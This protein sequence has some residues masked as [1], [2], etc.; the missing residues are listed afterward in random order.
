MILYGEK[1]LNLVSMR[2][3]KDDG[4]N[5]VTNVRMKKVLFFF[6]CL[7]V[8]FN[9]LCLAKDPDNLL[10]LI[11]LSRETVTQEKITSILGKPVK[12][13]ENNKKIWWHYTNDNTNLVICWNK[14]S[15]LFENFSFKNLQVEKTVC[16]NQVCRK[17]QSGATDIVQAL[18][19][20]GTPADMKNKGATQELHYAYQNSVLRLFFRN[21][22][23]VD[24]TLLSQPGK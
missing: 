21:H 2:C 15:D 6:F 24:F 17:L 1:I 8:A 23:L 13:E 5:L 16:N 11:G 18:K 22:V 20:L 7:L 10:S 14:K 3:K 12:I 9:N 4:I 19:L